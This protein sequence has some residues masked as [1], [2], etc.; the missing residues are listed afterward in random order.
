[1][2]YLT[3]QKGSENVQE[4]PL[5]LATQGNLRRMFR[6]LSSSLSVSQLVADFH[7]AIEVAEALDDFALEEGTDHFMQRVK[8]D[9][10][11]CYSSSGQ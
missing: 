7:Q 10:R 9:C 3:R 11:E 5:E 2:K 4:R 6:G 8:T 1:M